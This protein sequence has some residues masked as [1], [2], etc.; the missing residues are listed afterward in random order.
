MSPHLKVE[1]SMMSALIRNGHEFFLRYAG[2]RVFARREFLFVEGDG[3]DAIL[4]VKKGTIRLVKQDPSG[5]ERVVALFGPGDVLGLPEA[6]TET[7]YNLSAQARTKVVVTRFPAA[8]LRTLAQ[9]NPRIGLAVSEEMARHIRDLQRNVEFLSVGRAQERIA[10]LLVMLADR[11]TG[12]QDGLIGLPLTRQEIADMAGVTVETCIR[13]IS[14]FRAARLVRPMPKKTMLHRPAG[15][16]ERRGRGGLEKPKPPPSRWG[17]P[18]LSLR[19]GTASGARKTT[20][21]GGCF[22]RA[23]DALL[24]I[25][26]IVKDR[27][28][29]KKPPGGGSFS[30]MRRRVTG[31]AP[32]TREA[33]ICWRHAFVL[34]CRHERGISLF[35][36]PFRKNVVRRS[37]L[38]WPGLGKERR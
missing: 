36:S 18:L 27:R 11:W 17:R 28:S 19:I 2:T 1:S 21:T 4:I 35:A 9:K 10:N 6:M 13:T 38:P 31:E 15:A 30:D 26:S 16:G 3:A 24:F 5:R 7:A 25:R 34:T 14:K 37:V 32:N 22:S 23:P 20:R 29:E 8:T 12:E 33:P